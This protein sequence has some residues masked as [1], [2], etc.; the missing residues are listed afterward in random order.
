VG[1]P[2]TQDDLD[3]VRDCERAL[4]TGAV[5]GDRLSAGLLLHPDYREFGKSGRVWDK[6]SVLDLMEDTSEL[7]QIRAEDL[8]IVPLGADVVLVTY[9]SVTPQARA[10]RSSVWVREAGRWQ[11]R[12][13]Q[14]TPVPAA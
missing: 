7:V 9:D 6:E 12:F 2:I 1:A 10:R 13:H 14:G 3:I 11:V 4:L 5:R 8:E